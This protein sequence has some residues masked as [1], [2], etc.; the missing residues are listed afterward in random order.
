MD[1]LCCWLLMLHDRVV[2]SNLR[3]TQEIIASRLGARL[4]GI[5][6]AA[7]L[8]Q[9]MYAIDY[10]RGLHITD[11]EALERTACE[12]CAVMQ[13]EFRSTPPARRLGGRL[14]LKAAVSNR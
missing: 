10:R 6:V 8:L 13:N 1:R 14:T 2:D 9:T 5:I 12:C 11:R 4:A 7:R 3:L